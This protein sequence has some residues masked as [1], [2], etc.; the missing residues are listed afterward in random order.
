M[1]KRLT[2][3]RL[4]LPLAPDSKRAQ[5]IEEIAAAER[6]V[7]DRYTVTVGEMAD[8]LPEAYDNARQ[9]MAEAAIDLCRERARIYVTSCHWEAKWKDD[10]TI[11]VIRKRRKEQQDGKSQHCNHRAD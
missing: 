9:K 5:I 1:Q 2:N 7:Y 6:F 8:I 11:I 4:L 3:L 10:N